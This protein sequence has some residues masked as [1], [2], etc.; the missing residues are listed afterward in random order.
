M[1][2]IVSADWL[3]SRLDD[4]NVVPVDC[5]FYLQEKERGMEEYQDAHIPGAS[6][7]DLEK[8]LSG[9]VQGHGGRHP[10][11]KLDEFLQF[12]G[13]IGI[14]DS[15]TVVAYDAQNTA[16]AARLWWMLKYLGHEEA[17]VLDGGIHEWEKKGYPLT[18]KLPDVVKTTYR[19]NIKEDMVADLAEV[20]LASQLDDMILVDAR[21][22]E[23]FAGKSEPIDPKAGHIPTAQNKFFG[24]NLEQGK[25]KS[26]DQLKDRFQDQLHKP[27]INYCGSGVT[28]C[29][30]VLAL[31]EIDKKSKL[32][33]GSWSDWSSYNE[34]P[35]ETDQL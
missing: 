1:K 31:D 23:R 5:R 12:L 28:A 32:Y 25:W 26:K 29:V 16:M 17:Y 34:N 9:Q 18:E 19:P 22:G 15:K 2:N 11:P 13:A 4:S 24:D 21:D 33:V 20:K 3:H 35:V 7:A 8:N 10:L 14:D 6:Y 30:N 27:I